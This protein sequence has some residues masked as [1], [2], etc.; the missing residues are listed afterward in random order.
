MAGHLLST[1]WA[2]YSSLK[3]LIVSENNNLKLLSIGLY[4]TYNCIRIN[5]G[6]KCSVD[7][8]VMSGIVFGVLTLIN[9]VRVLKQRKTKKILKEVKDDAKA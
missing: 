7:S 5:T 8:I 9:L 4:L 1:I 2:I 6:L 3:Y